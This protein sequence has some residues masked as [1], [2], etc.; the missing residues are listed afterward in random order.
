MERVGSAIKKNKDEGQ[1]EKEKNKKDKDN[2]GH[3]RSS[4]LL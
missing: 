2:V 4:N 1:G 3:V